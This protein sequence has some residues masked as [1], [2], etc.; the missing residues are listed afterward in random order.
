MLIFG[1]RRGTFSRW[2]MWTRKSP[3]KFYSRFYV[4]VRDHKYGTVEFARELLS[5]ILQI[6]KSFLKSFEAYVDECLDFLQFL[7]YFFSWGIYGEQN[8]FT[9]KLQLIIHRRNNQT[10]WFHHYVLSNIIF[11][12][13]FHAIRKFLCILIIEK[14]YNWLNLIPEGM[15]FRL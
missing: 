5:I 10:M 11:Y 7:I 8:N 6:L 4:G 13:L 9:P 2:N 3:Y 12:L 15:Q 14:Y 1:F